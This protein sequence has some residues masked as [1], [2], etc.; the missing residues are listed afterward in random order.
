MD[1]TPLV[2]YVFYLVLATDLVNKYHLVLGISTGYGF[3]EIRSHYVYVLVR[4]N[5]KNEVCH[6]A[7]YRIPLSRNC[8][9][10]HS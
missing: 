7:V 5:A 9:I 2:A 4:G 1:K 6:D 8:I 10:I 3:S